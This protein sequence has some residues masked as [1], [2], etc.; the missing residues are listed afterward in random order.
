MEVLKGSTV[1]T[2]RS[3]LMQYPIKRAAFFGSF[4][5]A[6]AT[7]NSDADILVEFL[8]GTKGIEFFGLKVDLE[9]ALAR[10][11]DLVTYNA[12]KTSDDEFRENVER[13]AVIIY[14]RV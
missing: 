7:E 4:A 8:S 13:E 10:S 1:E 6:E 5:R 2:V 14:E 11:V 3:V 12:L 9:Q